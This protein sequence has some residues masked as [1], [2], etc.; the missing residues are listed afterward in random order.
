MFDLAG[1]SPDNTYDPDELRAVVSAIAQRPELPG[2]V[3]AELAARRARTEVPPWPAD[4]ADAP[5][6]WLVASLQRAAE[7]GLGVLWEVS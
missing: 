7:T 5:Y 4:A 1:R 6:V 2:Q 3:A